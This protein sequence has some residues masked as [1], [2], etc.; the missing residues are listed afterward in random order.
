MLWV[1]RFFLFSGKGFQTLNKSN[2]HYFLF[3]EFNLVVKTMD[4]GAKASLNSGS[5]T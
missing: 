5:S 3:S 4:S 1:F 2:L